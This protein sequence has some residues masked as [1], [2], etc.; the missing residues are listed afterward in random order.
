MATALHTITATVIRFLSPVRRW[1][2][3]G[4]AFAAFGTVVIAYLIL[5]FG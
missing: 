4:M 5:V 1:G 2:K 3:D